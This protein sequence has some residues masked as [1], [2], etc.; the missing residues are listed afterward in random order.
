MSTL[1]VSALLVGR[2]ALAG[3]DPLAACTTTAAGSGFL[4]RCG[5]VLLTELPAAVG[6]PASALAAA[7]ADLSR[8]NPGVAVRAQPLVWEGG[9]VDAVAVEGLGGTVRVA[10]VPTPLDGLRVLVCAVGGVTPVEERVCASVVA[11]AM[12]VGLPRGGAP[13]AGA[14]ASGAV[15]APAPAVVPASAPPTAPGEARFAGPE[16]FAVASLPSSARLDGPLPDAAGPRWRGA[17]VS[18]PSDCSWSLLAEAKGALTCADGVLTVGAVPVADSE[19]LLDLLLEPYRAAARGP[20]ATVSLRRLRGPCTLRG[21]AGR[22]AQ[23]DRLRADEGGDRVLAGVLADAGT[24]WFLVCEA[25]GLAPGLPVACA[26]W[27]GAWPPPR[28]G[29]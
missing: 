9:A 24:T 14:G 21:A 25:G 20:D 6:D 4:H 10:V 12:A 13:A 16:R 22:C 15:A 27:F 19:S 23:V 1:G 7:A 8:Q 11:H 18:V 29:R 28:S 3:A 17:P 26:P 2:L 5:R